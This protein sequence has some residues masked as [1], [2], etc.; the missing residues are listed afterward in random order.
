LQLEAL[1]RVGL[2]RDIST[3]LAEEKVNISNMNVTEHEDRTTSLFFV[4]QTT[5]IAQLSRVISRMEGIPGMVS[6][7]RVGENAIMKSG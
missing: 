2:V 6:V 1:D 7:T 5:G 4:L 3:L